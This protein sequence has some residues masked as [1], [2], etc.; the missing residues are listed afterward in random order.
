MNMSG[1][2]SPLRAI[3]PDHAQHRP[4][5]ASSLG[6]GVKLAVPCTPPPPISQRWRSMRAHVRVRQCAHHWIFYS[7]FVLSA[8]KLSRLPASEQICILNR[9]SFHFWFVCRECVLR[10]WDFTF[11]I[12]TYFFNAFLYLH[13]CCLLHLGCQWM[14]WDLDLWFLKTDGANWGYWRD[15]T[16]FGPTH[17]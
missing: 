11:F 2:Y 10:F 13:F 1:I 9:D 5:L 12:F 8:E 17:A 15:Y 16:N 7:F 3:I 4:F 6:C 14:T